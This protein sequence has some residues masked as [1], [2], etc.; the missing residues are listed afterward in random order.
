MISIAMSTISYENL[1]WLMKLFLVKKEDIKIKI[2]H[3][4]LH[5]C[6]ASLEIPD[7]KNRSKLSSYVHW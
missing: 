5:K 2:F 4:G 3:R 7:E 6:T 1:V